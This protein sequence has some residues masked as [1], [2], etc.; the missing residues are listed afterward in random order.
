MYVARPQ[1]WVMLKPCGKLQHVHPNTTKKAHAYTHTHTLHRSAT[2]PSPRATR[3]RY[4]SRHVENKAEGEETNGS[5][6]R[7]MRK[8]GETR[9]KRQ[10]DTAAVRDGY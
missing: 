2:V 8:R 6:R 5:R 4:T 9:D 7:K 10:A 3:A 1:I